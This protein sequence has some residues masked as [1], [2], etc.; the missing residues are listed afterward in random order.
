MKN[1]YYEEVD[2]SG[3]TTAVDKPGVISGRMKEMIDGD[4]LNSN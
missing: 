1:L 4:I 3:H 2:G